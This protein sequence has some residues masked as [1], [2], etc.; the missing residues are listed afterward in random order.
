MPLASEF[1]MNTND[2]TTSSTFFLRWKV[3][4][5]LSRRIVKREPNPL[6]TTH[7]SVLQK[8]ETCQGVAASSTPPIICY[9]SWSASWQGWPWWV[10]NQLDYCICLSAAVIYSSLL[11]I[12]LYIVAICHA[13]IILA[14]FTM[15]QK[16]QAAAVS[17]ILPL[18]CASISA[19]LTRPMNLPAWGNVLY[20][21]NIVSSK[22]KSQARH[23]KQTL[24]A[25]FKTYFKIYAV[26]C[27]KN[28]W[29]Q[30]IGK[31]Y[32]FIL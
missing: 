20:T 3:R 19:F 14:R 11:A 29:S 12:H 7:S 17:C 31:L 25:T 15:L 32:L 28:D 5:I 26:M 8:E 4:N 18:G 1:C 16:D 6:P 24:Q 27:V 13:H 23:G 22:M 30:C 10:K 9:L 2:G 21:I